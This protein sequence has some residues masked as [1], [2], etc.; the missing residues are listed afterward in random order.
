[1]EEF[2]NLRRCWL[3]TIR[4]LLLQTK[5]VLLI[6]GNFVL[7]TLTWIVVPVCVVVVAGLGGCA[8]YFRET[9]KRWFTTEEGTQRTNIQCYVCVNR[10]NDNFVFNIPDDT[11]YGQLKEIACRKLSSHFGFDLSGAKLTNINYDTYDL[12]R[13]VIEETRRG[14]DLFYLEIN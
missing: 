10:G 2:L 12:N 9:I 4:C 1:M 13:T 7:G 5:K 8:W 6:L 14:V 11:T 3:Q